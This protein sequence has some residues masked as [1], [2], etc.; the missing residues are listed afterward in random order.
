MR[1]FISLSFM[2]LVLFTSIV[3]ADSVQFRNGDQVE[4]TYVGGD[5]RTVRFLL[6]NGQME[7]YSKFA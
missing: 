2:I 3:L 6:E 7:T 4:G 1:Q 5:S